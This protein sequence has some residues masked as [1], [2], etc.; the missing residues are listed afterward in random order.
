MRGAAALCILP[1]PLLDSRLPLMNLQWIS[2]GQEAEVPMWRPA[3]RMSSG[4][5]G[6]DRP[7][8]TINAASS[9]FRPLTLPH[10]AAWATSPHSGPRRR[11]SESQPVV[12]AMMPADLLFNRPWPPAGGQLLSS[13]LSDERGG[14]F[15]LLLNFHASTTNTTTTTLILQ[16]REIFFQHKQKHKKTRIKY[17]TCESF[18]CS[19]W[20]QICLTLWRR[21]IWVQRVSLT[22]VGS[23]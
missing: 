23:L 2:F 8:T 10:P 7:S 11:P 4:S 12:V 3:D 16:Y 20:V 14:P 9:S 5:V 22:D 15:L 21:H 1:P 17:S 6:R 13:A 19:H 18:Q